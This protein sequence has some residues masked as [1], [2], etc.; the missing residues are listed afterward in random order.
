MNFQT[1]RAGKFEAIFLLGIFGLRGLIFGL[2]GLIFGL[3]GL[4]YG[5]RGLIMAL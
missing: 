1:S 5:L 2:R 3:R 4:I